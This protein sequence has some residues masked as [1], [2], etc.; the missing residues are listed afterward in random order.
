[1]GGNKGKIIII[2]KC[3]FRCQGSAGTSATPL[4]LAPNSSS[5]ADSEICL[6]FGNNFLIFVKSIFVSCNTMCVVYS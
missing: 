5:N 2:T 1:M 4:L 6:I 3:Y